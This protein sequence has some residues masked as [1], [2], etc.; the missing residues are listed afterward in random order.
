MGNLIF[1]GVSTEDLGLVIQAPPKYT[2]PAKDLST[3]HVPGRNGDFILDTYCYSNVD[4]TYSI[5]SVFR[6]GTDFMANAEKILKW[7]TE[8]SGYRRLEDTYDPTVYRLAMFSSSGSLTNYYDA[9]TS[10][11]VT[12]NCKPQRFLKIGEEKTDYFGTDITITN[13]TSET[14]SPLI[15]ISGISKANDNAIVLLTVLNKNDNK[16]SS[17]ITISKLPDN[18]KSITFDSEDQMVYYEDQNGNKK[19]RNAYVNFNRTDFPKLRKGKTQITIGNYIESTEIIEKYENLLV[20]NQQVMAAK[21]QPYDAIIE[22]RQKKFFVKKYTK[23]KLDKEEVYDAKAYLNLCNDKAEKYSFKSYNSLLSSNGQVAA[24][25]GMD[26]VFPEWLSVTDNKN[27]TLTCRLARSDIYTKLSDNI[28]G[29]YVMDGS[30]KRIRYVTTDDTIGTY[31]DT[32]VVNI[33]FYPAKLKDGTTTPELAI[34]YDDVPAWLSYEIIYNEVD[35]SPNKIIYK[36]N[37]S[38]EG[39]YYTEKTSLFGK[40]SWHHKSENVDLELGSATWSTWKKSFVST[41]GLSISTT[42]TFDYKYLNEA[43]QYDDVTE[44]KKDSDGNETTE[45]L[46]KVHFKI[47]P[48]TEDL[49]KV[50]ATATEDGYFRLNDADLESGF[51]FVKKGTTIGDFIPDSTKSNTIYYLPGIPNYASEKEYPSWLYPDLYNDD[52]TVIDSIS[53]SLINFKV[54][55]KAYYRYSY[56]DEETQKIKYTDWA[57]LKKDAIW[58]TNF[59]QTKEYTVYMITEKDKLSNPFSYIDASGNKIDNI[60]FYDKNDD[61]YDGNLPPDFVIISRKKGIKDDG[62]SDTIK[63]TVGKSGYFKWDSN[64]EWV[65]FEKGKE[66]V[67]STLNDDTTIYYLATLPKYATSDP[68]RMEIEESI[69]GNPTTIKVFASKEGYFKPQSESD[70]VRYNQNDPIVESKISEET[71]IKYLVLDTTS[72]EQ[73]TNDIKISIIPRWWKI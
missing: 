57:L 42:A 23:L 73:E 17:S 6:P 31:K 25:I 32:A 1:N 2:F 46:A 59:M 38:S 34:V 50:S 45:L 14:A 24:F 69:S 41:S 55:D 16:V 52:G 12:F 56:M 64:L 62:S 29:G 13:P 36:A 51:K 39:Y 5:A 63:Y 8:P 66:I 40:A 28:Y 15:T 43:P 72:Q 53:P 9:A 61:V 67:S 37:V 71:T 33:S 48:L 44:T 11:D 3:S 18:E 60:G 27:G 26:S 70:W 35:H 22:S 4:R 65:Y 21:Y 47:S 7:L 54:K 30:D 68:V 20:R 19:D 58:Q 49:T 10:I